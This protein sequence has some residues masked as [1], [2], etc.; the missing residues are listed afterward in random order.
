MRTEEEKLQKRAREIETRERVMA[1]QKQADEMTEADLKLREKQLLDEIEKVD[2][3]SYNAAKKR[4]KLVQQ[5][6]AIERLKEMEK[7]HDELLAEKMSKMT[8][9]E[10]FDEAISGLERVRNQAMAMDPDDCEEEP[11]T[12]EAFKGLVA[13]ANNPE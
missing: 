2:K 4:D 7:K 10:L 9:Q 13:W 11:F 12:E 8:P 3:A 1:F 5:M 6:K